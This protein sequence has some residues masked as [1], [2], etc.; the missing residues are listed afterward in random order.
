MWAFTGGLQRSH[1]ALDGVLKPLL[2]LIGNPVKL[3]SGPAAVTLLFLLLV[4]YKERTLLAA[5][6]T[7]ST[8]RD[9]KVAKRAG[10]P[11]DLPCQFAIVLRPLKNAHFCP[12]WNGAKKGIWQWF[13]SAKDRDRAIH[14]KGSSKLGAALQAIKSLKGFCIL[15]FCVLCLVFSI[16]YVKLYQFVR[17]I[18]TKHQI[19]NT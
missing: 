5:N 16:T 2:S 3:G 8:N 7:V 17:I 1:W 11:E 19:L 13:H 18:N 6:T 14:I 12:R 15:V 9:G 4:V 10:E